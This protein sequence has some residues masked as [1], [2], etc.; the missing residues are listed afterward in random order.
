MYELPTAWEAYYRELEPGRRKALLDG[1]L[2]TEA[3]DGANAYRQRLLA[4]RTRPRSGPARRRTA[5]S[6]SA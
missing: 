6:I 4:A 1:L 5:F 2:Q 3:D